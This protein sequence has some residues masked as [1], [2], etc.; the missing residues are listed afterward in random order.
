MTQELKRKPWLEELAQVLGLSME[1]MRLLSQHIDDSVLSLE[2][3]V[4]SKR[5][6]EE[7]ALGSLIEDKTSPL[8]EEVLELNGLQE[9]VWQALESLSPREQMVMS[10]RFGL[11]RER[12]LLQREIGEKLGVSR[13][14]V[15]NIIKGAIAQLKTNGSWERLKCYLG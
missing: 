13:T 6:G 2:M 15:Q 9:D 3:P 4:K 10:L 1:E 7:T 5:D 11:K 14:T 8:P 12:P